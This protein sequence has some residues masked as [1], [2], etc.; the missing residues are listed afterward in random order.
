MLNETF[1]VIFKH[2]VTVQ[3]LLKIALKF[4]F[5]IIAS[6]VFE[7]SRQNQMLESN[8]VA[9]LSFEFSRQIQRKKLWIFLM[10]FLGQ[11]A[12]GKLSR[13]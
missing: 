3:N 4:L 13:F 11:N 1:S 12:L 5:C 6:Y 2:C 7:F 10:E 8:N 9:L